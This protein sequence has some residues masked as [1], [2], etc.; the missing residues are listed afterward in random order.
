MSTQPINSSLFLILVTIH[1]YI[2]LT[3]YCILNSSNYHVDHIIRSTRTSFAPLGCTFTLVND[4]AFS[5]TNNNITKSHAPKLITTSLYICKFFNKVVPKPLLTGV[6]STTQEGQTVP[7]SQQLIHACV[8]E[9][10]PDS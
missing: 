5:N 4:P 10:G 7:M 6:S 8:D 1:S 2:C 9:V 3:A